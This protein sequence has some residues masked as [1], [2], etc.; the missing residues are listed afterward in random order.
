MANEARDLILKHIDE[1]ETIELLQALVRD[2]KS[3]NPPGDGRE[4]IRICQEKLAAEG[5]ECERIGEL[6]IMPILIATLDRGEGPALMYNAH[7][8]VVPTGNLDAWDYPPFEGRVVNGRVYGRGAGDDKASVVAQIMGAIAVARSGVPIKG[9]L[10]VNIDGDEETGGLHGAQYMVANMPRRPDFVVA[11][12]QTLNRICVGER[13]ISNATITV[14]GRAAHAALPWEGVN[15]IDGMVKILT[16]LEYE[17]WPKLEARRHPLFDPPSTHTVS[18]IEGGVRENVVPDRCRVYIDRRLVPGETSED[19]VAEVA[20]IAERVIATIPGMRVEVTGPTGIEASLSDPD[21]QLVKAMAAANETLGL[22]PSPIGYNM[23]TDGRHFAAAG[24]PTVIYG[25]GDYS[26]AHVPNEWVGVD[27][28]ME[29]TRAY[30]LTA[31][32]MLGE[33]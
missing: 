30:A 23:A 12:E 32:N 25:P 1:T 29:A 26:L 15:A 2:E 13:G 6:D 21:S 11:G 33:K 14:Y 22:D 7:V 9:A 19:A 31:Y 4:S 28:V 18:M 10:I 17:L 8:D 27:E 20:S 16:A 3:V 24:I 5:F